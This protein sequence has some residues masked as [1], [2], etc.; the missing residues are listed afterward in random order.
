MG[1]TASITDANITSTCS[2]N[3]KG[4]SICVLQCPTGMSLLGRNKQKMK[5][6][7]PRQ[8]NG[9]RT[10]GWILRKSFIDAAGLGGLACTGTATGGGNGGGGAAPATN[11]P[12]T[13]APVT[14]APV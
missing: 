2:T 1:P 4:K 3:A 8:S 7:C 14:N 12:V 6:K 9:T 10:C 11:A 5:C 13:N